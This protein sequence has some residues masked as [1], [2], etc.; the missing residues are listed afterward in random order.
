MTKPCG[1]Q[2]STGQV[3]AR[4]ADQSR[5]E[6]DCDQRDTT[7]I[8]GQQT[9]GRQYQRQNRDLKERA[10]MSSRSIDRTRSLWTD[11][12]AVSAEGKDRQADFGG[13]RL[14]ENEVEQKVWRPHAQR[15]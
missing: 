7:E 5:R 13:R 14:S 12:T 9:H 2:Q 10:E 4:F 6:K 3:A 1:T 8:K 11:N 15:L